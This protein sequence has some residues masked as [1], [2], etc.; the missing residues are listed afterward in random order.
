LR[1]LSLHI[2]DIVQNSIAAEATLI[3]IEIDEDIARNQLKITISDNGQGMSPETI[4]KVSD[5]FY[6]TRTTRNLGF[7]IPFFKETAEDSGGKLE[8]EST[9]GQGTVVTATMEREHIN[10]PPLGNIAETM[11]IILLSDPNIF[12]E[13]VHR[14][15]GR[16]LTFTNAE[17]PDLFDANGNV[18]FAKLFEIKQMIVAEE[19]KLFFK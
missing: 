12:F 3:S 9:V 5:P 10:R 1:E 15:N 18:N 4:K 13:Y 11:E 7:G 2:L 17:H 16:E 14:V 8:I 6:T 19:K